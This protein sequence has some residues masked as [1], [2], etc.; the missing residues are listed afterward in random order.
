MNWHRISKFWE[1]LW[2]LVLVNAAAFRLPPAISGNSVGDFVVLWND[3]PGLEIRG[4]IL[5]DDGPKK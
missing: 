4:H 5:R 3:A 1:I 2:I